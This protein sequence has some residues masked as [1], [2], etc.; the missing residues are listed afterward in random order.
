MMTYMRGW[1]LWFQA[2]SG[3]ITNIEQKNTIN[4]FLWFFYMSF[5]AIR[6]GFTLAGRGTLC[7]ALFVLYFFRF[8]DLLLFMFL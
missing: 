2:T 8:V 4:K 1:H 6:Q 3:S 7:S 5:D